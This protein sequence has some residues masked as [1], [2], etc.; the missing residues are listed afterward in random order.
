MKKVMRVLFKIQFVQAAMTVG[1]FSGALLRYILTGKRVQGGVY[2]FKDQAGRNYTISPPLTHAIPGLVLAITN[3]KRPVIWAFIGSFIAS[4]VLGDQIE[5]RV[6]NQI[7]AG[8]EQMVGN[9]SA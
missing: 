4:V 8:I 3:R 5:Q 1:S 9:S 2:R 7:A 6:A